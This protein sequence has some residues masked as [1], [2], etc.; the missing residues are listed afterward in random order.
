LLDWTLVICTLDRFA[1]LRQALRTA[2][3]QT[4]LPRQ[5]IIVD[6]SS[7]WSQCR[8]EVLR[9][10][11][12]L[13]PSMEWIYLGSE[14]RSL[15]HQRNLG[16][17]SCTSEIV[18][19]FDD[20]SFMF[21]DCAAEIMSVYE[22]DVEHRI[23]G[24]SAMLSPDNPLLATSR[25]VH[26]L[27]SNAAVRSSYGPISE[28]IHSFW[29]QHKLFIPYD[30][31]YHRHA[32]E[33][34]WLEPHVSAELLFHGCRM[35]FRTSAVLEAGGCDEVLIRQCFAEDVDL[36]YR[37]SRR[38]PIVLNRKALLFHALTEG[39]RAGKGI[40]ATLVILNAV[41]LYR[42]HASREAGRNRVAYGFA[43]RR[44]A[45]E[46]LRD[47]I[48]PWRGFPN[49]RGVLRALRRMPAVLRRSDADLR[50]DY[51]SI[52]REIMGHRRQHA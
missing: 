5:I 38:H 8:D 30:G 14:Q 2:V 50:R 43:L 15:T 12:S 44:L 48:K 18:F 39:A 9:E 20:D 11:G 36:S 47:A 37:V 42:L 52:Q 45:V 35:T 32:G 19:L 1:V 25:E 3:S 28:L 34:P 4:R 7:N 26:A 41:V 51:P 46:L 49:A 24:V 16:L 27:V 40:Q 33:L 13:H 22:H 17:R 21:P 10:F 23:G 6:A 29:D 31:H